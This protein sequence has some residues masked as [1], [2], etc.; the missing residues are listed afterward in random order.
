MNRS[1]LLAGG[2]RKHCP[3]F[4]GELV[5]GKPVS[6]C[7]REVVALSIVLDGDTCSALEIQLLSAPRDP[8]ARPATV[9][10]ASNTPS[11]TSVT[12]FDVSPKS[13]ALA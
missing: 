7:D 9:S 12:I 4:N 11:I 6:G 1:P 10:H 8:I 5:S 2:R 3:E 13:H